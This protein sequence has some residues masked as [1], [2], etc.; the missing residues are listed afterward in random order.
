[1]STSVRSCSAARAQQGGGI[2]VLGADIMII[3]EEF[4]EWEN[5]RCRV[6]VLALDRDV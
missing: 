4:G 6:D 2:R 1:M 3:S 5:S